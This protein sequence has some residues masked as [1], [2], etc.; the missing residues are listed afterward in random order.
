MPTV[1]IAWDMLFPFAG[2]H[3]E[4]LRRAGFDVRL[5]EKR[6]ASEAE[7]IEA[8]RGVAAVIAGGEPYTHRVLAS[9]PELRV[10]S[11]AGV[12]TDRVDTE[13]ATRHRVVVTI[14]PAGN[15][16][17]VAEHALTML[18]ALAR[19]VVRHDQEV[20]RGVW[21]RGA[22]QPLRG[23]TLGIVGLGR[24]GRAVAVRAAAFRMR[25][26]A[27]EE[28]PDAEFVRHHGIELVDLDRLLALSDFVTL[29]VPLTAQTRGLINRTTL[30][31]MKRGSY[32][33]NTA[34]GGLVVEPDLLEALRSGQL[35]GAGLD[36]FNEEPTPAHNP[37]LQLENVLVS[38]HLAGGDIQG[39]NDMALAAAQ[40]I[41]D[42]HQGKWP[43][44][45]VV[46]P[47]VRPAWRW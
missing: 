25:L 41:I 38:P 30:A 40:N 5:A 2:P 8:L 23:R 35:A 9:L 43:E 15:H 32:L 19:S 33:V 42:L 37:L 7:T 18:L 4:Q 36:V 14:T 11:R 39:L 28:F 24:I 44:G 26:L 12:G 31:G 22:L 16:E 20:R 17:A 46:N 6:L 3:V 1:V 27:C 47:A 34:R 13:A 45:S 21:S 29:H 10:V